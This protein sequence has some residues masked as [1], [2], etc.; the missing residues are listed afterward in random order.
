MGC[1]DSRFLLKD[2]RHVY[3][4]VYYDDIPFTEKVYT[5]KQQNRCCICKNDT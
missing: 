2:S 1:S 4:D 3:N 5:E